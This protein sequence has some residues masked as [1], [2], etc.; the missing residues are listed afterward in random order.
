MQS[1]SGKADCR[2][3]FVIALV[4]LA[5]L[6]SCSSN[7]TI[8]TSDLLDRDSTLAPHPSHASHGMTETRER[9][10][11]LNGQSI[12]GYTT[13]D[14]V[15]HECSGFARWVDDSLRFTRPERSGHGM[16]LPAPALTVTLPVEQVQS[17]RAD[18]TNRLNVGIGLA[19]LAALVGLGAMGA[20]FSSESSAM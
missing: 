13:I 12:L 15:Y 9:F 4:A 14:G 5:A 18:T 1:A 10:R 2:S 17:I 19:L 6:S 16:E 20:A 3:L 11:S 7:R 8:P